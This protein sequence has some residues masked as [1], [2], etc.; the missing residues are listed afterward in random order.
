MY[1][2]MLQD[3]M[4]C[5]HLSSPFD[6][7]VIQFCSFLVY[8]F[9]HISIS[10]RG[11]L[12]SPTTT[13][14]GSICIFKISSVYLLKLDA[15]TLSAYKL[16]FVISSWLLFLWSELFLSLLSNLGLKSTLSKCCYSCL[17]SGP[18]GW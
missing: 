14:L 16:M 12:K 3:W 13:M 4:L 5:K 9:Y 15:L 1:I 11:V 6:L 18:L 10:D 17:F 2:V 7:G 8:F